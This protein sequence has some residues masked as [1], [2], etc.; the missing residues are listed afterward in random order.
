[1]RAKE[2]LYTNRQGLKHAEIIGLIIGDLL[3]LRRNKE[4]TDRYASDRLS[5]D[6]RYQHY[7]LQQK[8]YTRGNA[9]QPEIPTYEQVEGE[10]PIDIAAEVRDELFRVIRAD[11]SFGYLF[12]FLGTEQNS[13]H[14]GDPIDCIPNAERI[15]QCIDENRDDYPQVNLDHFLN[16]D[17]NYQQY[18]T[19]MRGQYW[20]DDNAIY[21]T[22]FNRVYAIFDELRLKKHSISGVRQF[23][24]EQHFE[25]DVQKY[26]TLSYIA[27]IIAQYHSDDAHLSRCRQELVRIIVSHQ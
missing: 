10:V 9:L 23:L 18:D 15:A 17:F 6:I 13:R 2:F 26:W 20:E 1:M 27:S 25:D 22:Y 11:G 16:D 24:R 3:P 5:A 21:L 8:L 19:L 4:A 14:N 7:L 12:Y